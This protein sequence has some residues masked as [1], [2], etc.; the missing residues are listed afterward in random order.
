[1]IYDGIVA[2]DVVLAIEIRVKQQKLNRLMKMIDEKKAVCIE[3]NNY[4]CLLNGEWMLRKQVGWHE[5]AGSSVLLTLLQLSKSL[6]SYKLLKKKKIKKKEEK[7][8]K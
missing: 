8:N 4:S 5:V 2:N 6:T 1:M 7:G 3:D